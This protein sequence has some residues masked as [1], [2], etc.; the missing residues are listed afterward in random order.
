MHP[1]LRNEAYRIASEAICNACR[2]SGAT[3]I[4]VEICYDVRQLRVRVKDNGKGVDQKILDGGGREEHYGL[5]GM[6][7]RAK[8]A[9]GKLTVGSRPESGTE[10]ELIIPASI[11]YAKSSAPR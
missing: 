10:I 3:R 5:P 2:H 8:L 6:Y 9:G 7:E 1:I 11:A 4:D